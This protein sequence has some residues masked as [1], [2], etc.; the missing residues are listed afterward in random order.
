MSPSKRNL[1]M[2]IVIKKRKDVI[3]FKSNF[4]I[5][6]PYIDRLKEEK[7][8]S[9][10]IWNEFSSVSLTLFHANQLH[11]E[12]RALSFLYIC[13]ANRCRW[14]NCYAVKQS[15]VKVNWINNEC[16]LRRNRA[17]EQKNTNKIVTKSILARKEVGNLFCLF[18]SLSLLFS[19]NQIV[20]RWLKFWELFFNWIES[21]RECGWEK[22]VVA[23]ICLSLFA[24][25]VMEFL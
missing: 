25:N 7:L 6:F 8:I 13:T 1:I 11:V 15:H 24:L 14:P 2:G 10:P 4:T 18:F 16:S 23:F 21:E 9:V 22:N 5:F 20:Q 17:N 3:F 12:L 19:F